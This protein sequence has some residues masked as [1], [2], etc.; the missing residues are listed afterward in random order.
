MGSLVTHLEDRSTLRGVSLALQ[1]VCR[2][3]WRSEASSEAISAITLSFHATVLSTSPIDFAELWTSDSTSKSSI[4]DRSDCVDLDQ[5]RW[6]CGEGLLCVGFVLTG[7]K[8]SL[9]IMY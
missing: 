9:A 6:R 5:A 3:L 4:T 8:E 2:S 1:S 7:L